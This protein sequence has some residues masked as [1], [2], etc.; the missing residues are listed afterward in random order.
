[1]P[2]A[3]SDHAVRASPPCR[4]S[5]VSHAGTIRNGLGTDELRHDGNSQGGVFGPAR[6]P[7]GLALFIEVDNRNQPVSVFPALGHDRSA[8]AQKPQERGS[9]AHH[10]DLT[11]R[12]TPAVLCSPGDPRRTRP[13]S[14]GGAELNARKAHRPDRRLRRASYRRRERLRGTRDQLPGF[15]AVGASG[16]PVVSRLMNARTGRSTGVAEP[17]QPIIYQQPTRVRRGSQ[18]DSGSTAPPPCRKR[19][20]KQVAILEPIASRY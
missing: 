5:R 10:T 7:S 19:L 3:L 18:E 4:C 17:R 20:A 2:A 14:A 11:L 16:G 6:A 13:A 12:S 1:M 8:A 9:G 15:A